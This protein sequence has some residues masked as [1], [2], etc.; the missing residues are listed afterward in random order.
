MAVRV[1]VWASNIRP[2]AVLQLTQ[3]DVHSLGRNRV[4]VALPQVTE[5]ID[6]F[7]I[8]EG[9]GMWLAPEKRVVLW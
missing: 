8:K 9:D 2:E 4:N 6:A 7:G 3:M 1:C 5:F